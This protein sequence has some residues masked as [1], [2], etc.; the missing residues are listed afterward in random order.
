MAFDPL[1]FERTASLSPIKQRGIIMSKKWL[2]L[3]TATLL[4]S[5][6]LAGTQGA[7]NLGEVNQRIAELL[8]EFN[9]ERT[10]ATVVFEKLE[11][12]DVAVRELKANGLLAKI[13][14]QNTLEIRVPKIN[15]QNL[16]G[17]NDPKFAI[18]AQAKLDLVKAFG[19]KMID[20]LAPAADDIV[21]DFLSEFTK[22][23]GDAAV[24]D[25]A[26]DEINRDNDGHVLSLKFHISGKIDLTKLPAEKPIEDEAIRS[27]QLV[28]EVT[29]TQAQA[30]LSVEM[31]P[32]YKYFGEDEIGLKELVEGL[33]KGD[34]ESYESILSTIRSLDS[35]AD[36]I[37]ERNQKD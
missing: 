3:V 15:Y 21:K 10:A 28:I 8:K 20:D 23:Y 27:G 5:V 6:A 7:L 2:L 1:P 18:D 26:V 16:A 11:S 37:V 24:I 35:L 4:G 32:K 31:N 33:L 25:A 17:A 36:S 19:Q 22:G 30:K 12:D 34:K 14:S 13:G 29:R 9:N